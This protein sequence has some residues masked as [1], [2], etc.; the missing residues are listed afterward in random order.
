MKDLSKVTNDNGVITA[1][2]IDQRN[3]LKQMLGDLGTTENMSR[4]KEI[5]SE[6]LS[7]HAAAILLDP[8]Y[9]LSA[10]QKTVESCAAILSY[11]VS[12]YK[13]D[14]P[15]R[16]PTL[17]DDWSAAKLKDNGADAI[18]L[19]VYYDPDEGDEINDRKKTLIKCVGDECAASEL[20]FFLEIITYDYMSDDTKDKAFALKRPHKINTSMA[21]FSKPEYHVDVLKVEVPVNMY[22][23]EG[24]GGDAVYTQSEARDFFK[25]QNDVT[26]VPFIFLSGGVPTE[27]FIDTLQFAHDAGSNF[28]GILGGRAIWKESIDIFVNDGEAAAA[29]WMQTKGK[30]NILNIMNLVDKIARPIER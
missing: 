21:E 2:A 30:E 18:K 3:S 12:G 14:E 19:L 6:N 24:F 23:V 29:E 17:L 16:L 9:G 13:K 27:M 11:E 5:V 7:P 22:F 25:A 1:L 4:F 26:K 28:N 10:A 8:Q 20:P 15:G